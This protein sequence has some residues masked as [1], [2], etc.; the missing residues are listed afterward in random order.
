MAKGAA[1]IPA[2]QHDYVATRSLQ[3]R[4]KG[5][6]CVGALLLTEPVGLQLVSTSH[7]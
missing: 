3:A 6:L 1:A 5:L 7:L 2:S 4:G